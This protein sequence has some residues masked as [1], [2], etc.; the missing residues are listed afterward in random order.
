M[1]AKAN[2]IIMSTVRKITFEAMVFPWIERSNVKRLFFCAILTGSLPLCDKCG[3][4]DKRGFQEENTMM[5][6]RHSTTKSGKR[7][8]T[9][10]VEKVDKPTRISL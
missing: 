1:T 7:V 3:A 4:A 6:F 9:T 8:K 2:P 5:K 10:K